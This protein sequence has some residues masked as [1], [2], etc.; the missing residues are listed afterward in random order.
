[1]FLFAPDRSRSLFV[2]HLTAAQLRIMSHQHQPALRR[3]AP[4]IDHSSL[5]APVFAMF[6]PAL[7]YAFQAIIAVQNRP[8]TRTR[9][10]Y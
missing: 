1:M 2:E 7:V 5:L 3:K 10:I 8:N 9:L 6:E 4:H